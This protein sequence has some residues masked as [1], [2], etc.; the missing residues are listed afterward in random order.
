[1]KEFYFTLPYSK[2]KN[3]V[4]LKYGQVKKKFIVRTYDGKIN[5]RV[6]TEDSAK[7]ETFEDE[8]EMLKRVH[9]IK[10]GLMQSRW[11]I[12]DKE[13]IFQPS[14]LK[15]KIIDG[16][17]SFEFTVDIDP[18]KLEGRRKGIAQDFVEKIDKEVET[19]IRK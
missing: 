15:T 16:S 12:Q 18:V 7:E 9:E 6:T 8:K 17:I 3:T 4:R 19:S 10:K 11:V 13:P 1:M 14:F 5:D 2:S